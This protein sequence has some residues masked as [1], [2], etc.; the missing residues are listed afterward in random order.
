MAV[1]GET[2]ELKNRVAARVVALRP[3]PPVARSVLSVGRGGALQSGGSRHRLSLRCHRHRPRGPDDHRHRRRLFDQG[4]HRHPHHRHE[5]A[6]GLRQGLARP[7]VRRG[8]NPP[9][10]GVHGRP[11]IGTIIKPALGLRPHE[12][13][14]L[15]QGCH[16][17]RRGLRQGRR[18]AD[19][20]GLFAAGGARQ[21]DHADDPRARAEDRHEGDVCLGHLRD[22]P[23]RDDAQP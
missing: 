22:R 18:E 1:P 17:R 12:T 23:G 9:A 20:A 11:I 4:L 14:A 10:D 6:R 5:A 15:V 13:A 21:G 2:E 3:L 19:V 7:A 8:R 16:R